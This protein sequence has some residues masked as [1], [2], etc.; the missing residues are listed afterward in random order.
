MLVMASRRAN[1]DH[2]IPEESSA[3]RRGMVLGLTLA[4]AGLL[5]IFV[6]LLLLAIGELASEEQEREAQQ[7]VLALQARLAALEKSNDI[8]TK[9]EDAVGA[10]PNP[11]PEDVER[12]VQ[13]VLKMTN[14]RE[15]E[16]ALAA[17]RD[18]LA[19]WK[20]AKERLTRITEQVMGR[21]ANAF[22]DKVDELV[23]ENANKEGQLARYEQ[24]LSSMGLGKGER[25]CW[26]QPDTK[27]IEF[28][29][30][31]ILQSD[32]LRMREVVNPGR[33][34]D[35]ARLPMPEVDP[36]RVMTEDQFINLTRPLFDS[37][38]AQNCRFFVVVYD[39]TGLNEKV[40]Y[41]R[42]LK[43]VEGH[44]YKRL[45]DGTAAF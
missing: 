29:F 13:M 3:Y 1:S 27:K 17:A 45:A 32:G 2:G 11:R 36:Q 30:D 22:V 28:L 35:R 25:P 43:A 10:G 39:A 16:S 41:I 5:I 4:E 33:V 26:V 12:L 7:S 44:F 9:L 8:V 34:A 20:D 14:S 18:E 23:S 38:L 40:R 37:S 31:V 19:E 15:G 42:L 24:R 21:E 6:L